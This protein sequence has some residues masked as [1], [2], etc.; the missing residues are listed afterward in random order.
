MTAKPLLLSDVKMPWFGAKTGYELLPHYLEG[1]DK[2]TSSLP[3]EV[4]LTSY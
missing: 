3:R 2:L 4:L 1:L